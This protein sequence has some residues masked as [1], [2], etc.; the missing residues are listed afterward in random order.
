MTHRFKKGDLVYCADGPSWAIGL[1]K[2][3][4]PTFG[5][6]SISIIFGTKLDVYLGYEMKKL[7]SLDCFLLGINR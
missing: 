5:T 7:R 6:Y 1:V 3:Y 4:K 2:E